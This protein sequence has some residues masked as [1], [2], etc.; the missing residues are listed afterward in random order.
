MA[1]LTVHSSLSSV[2]FNDCKPAAHYIYI[3][4]I[5]IMMFSLI[6]AY[7]RIMFEFF[8]AKKDQVF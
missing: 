3:Y 5:T 7:N 6:V 4:R 8:K 1:D 2:V